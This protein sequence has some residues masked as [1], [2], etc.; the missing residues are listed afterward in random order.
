MSD[1][2]FEIK[3]ATKP[4]RVESSRMS[5]ETELRLELMESRQQLADAKRLVTSI[6]KYIREIEEELN[7]ER[8]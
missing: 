1:F 5:R 6:E 3:I 8:M 7:N 4:E 2:T